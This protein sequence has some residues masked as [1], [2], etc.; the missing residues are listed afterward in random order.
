MVKPVPTPSPALTAVTAS[1]TQVVLSA[2]PAITAQQSVA[3]VIIRK[4]LKIRN[5]PACRLR[6]TIRNA[7][8]VHPA[9]EHIPPVPAPL[10]VAH[11][12]IR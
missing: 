12:D 3:A 6:P 1:A 10:I 11:P 9:Q 2:V 4:I 7:I 5:A 8:V